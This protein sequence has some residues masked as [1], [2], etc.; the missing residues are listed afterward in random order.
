MS[1]GIRRA[2]TR[3]S[4]RRGTG[5]RIGASHGSLALGLDS[6]LEN[7]APDLARVPH[8]GLRRVRRPSAE[9]RRV[10]F[11]SQADRKDAWRIFGCATGM[12]LLQGAGWW[13]VEVRET[14]Q[15]VGTVGAFFREG[16]PE[17]EIGWNTYQAFWRRGFASEAAGEVLRYALEVR[18]ERRVTALIDPGNTASLRVAAHL[19]MKH[20]SDT[21]LWGNPIG[22]YWR[23]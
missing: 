5:R 2:S 20:E 13:S 12:W 23:A 6:T 16:W 21:E 3:A 9:S 22:R 14:G 8:G 17:M 11:I 19:G 15:L 10:A 4:P 1:R 7:G 18:K